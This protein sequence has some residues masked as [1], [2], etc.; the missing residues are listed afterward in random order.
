[1]TIHRFATALGIAVVA[2][3]LLG[4][5]QSNNQGQIGGTIVGGAAGGILGSQIGGGSGRTVATIAGTLLGAWVGNSVGRSL[6][7]Q[8]QYQAQQAH[9]QALNSGQPIQW[10][11]P[12]NGNYGSVTPMRDGYNQRS[13]AYC[14]EF[15]TQIVVGGQVQNAYGTAC[16]Q[17]DGSWRIVDQR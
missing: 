2:G 14:R 10:N 3:G 4:A 12:N 1:M 5:C 8:S 13:G 7:Q 15:Q 11:N 16:Q 6:D 9:V 17:P